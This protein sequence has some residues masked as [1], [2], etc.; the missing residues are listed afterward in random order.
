M[1]KHTPIPSRQVREQLVGKR[2]SGVIARPGRPP[3]LLMLRFD[4]GSVMEFLSP[5][6]ERQGRSMRGPAAR[7]SERIQGEFALAPA[8]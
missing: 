8:R 4:D 1:D 3:T 7:N 2:I 6:I 5:S